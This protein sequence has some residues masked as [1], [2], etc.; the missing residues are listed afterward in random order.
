MKNHHGRLVAVG[1]LLAA[2]LLVLAAR[3]ELP[4]KAHASPRP[5]A[6]DTQTVA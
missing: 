6:A 1:C 2:F 5:V 4:A 3:H